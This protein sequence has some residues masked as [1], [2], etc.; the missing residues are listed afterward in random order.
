MYTSFGATKN[1]SGNP[2]SSPSSRASHCSFVT[3]QTIAIQE[4]SGSNLTSSAPSP[5]SELKL[6][7]SGGGGIAEN[8]GVKK[9]EDD[10]VSGFDAGGA[11]GMK[12]WDGVARRG[13]VVGC[14]ASSAC[15]VIDRD[16]GFGSLVSGKEIRGGRR[17][18]GIRLLIPRPFT[19]V[20]DPLLFAVNPGL[21]LRLPIRLWSLLAGR[22]GVRNTWPPKDTTSTFVWSGSWRSLGTPR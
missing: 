21:E 11:P 2:E 1:P 9:S 7:P 6:A 22:L 4:V 19:K 17:K 15:G 3:P 10:D 20:G 14:S 5:I 18:S 13:D 8:V 12:M 16:E